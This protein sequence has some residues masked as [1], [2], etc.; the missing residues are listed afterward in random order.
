[1]AWAAAIILGALAGTAFGQTAPQWPVELFRPAAPHL[2]AVLSGRLR[3]V[4]GGLAVD[5]PPMFAVFGGQERRLPKFQTAKPEELAALPDG[6]IELQVSWQYPDLDPALRERARAAATAALRGATV[7][8][9]QEG[10]DT[11]LFVPDNASRIARWDS[12][13]AGADSAAFLRLALVHEMV[14]WL[15]DQQYGLAKRR[16]ACRDSEELVALQALVEGRCQW[17][18]RQVARRLGDNA[19]FALLAEAYH[20]APDAEGDGTVRVLCRDVL[21]RRRWCCVRGLAF[22]DYLEAQGVKDAEARA[23]AHPP[24]LTTWIER[25][26]LYLRSERL[27]L[28]DLGKVL[29]RMEGALPAA[30]WQAEQQP[31]TP[32]MFCDVAAMLGEGPRAQKLAQAWDAGRSLIWSAR[33]NPMRQV[34][35]GVQRFRDGA[36]ARAYFGLTV[37]LQQKAGALGRKG[38]LPPRPTALRLDGADEGMRADK[39]MP[40]GDRGESISVTQVWAR[41]GERVVEFS[42]MGIPADTDWAQRVLDGVLKEK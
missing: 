4:P 12:T 26:E 31:W 5:A 29:T 13:L 20:R 21:E 3:H 28:P 2:E 27:N 18:T 32:A 37:D 38:N 33:T 39:Q 25:P 23:F 17:V 40:I 24:R 30:E 41:A 19:T 9:L 35:L 16:E 36:A 14:R 1:M 15:L 10:G 11:I 8:G 7:A 6:L 22:F 34:A 42:W